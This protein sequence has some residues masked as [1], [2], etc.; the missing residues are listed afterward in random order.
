MEQAPLMLVALIHSAE[1]ILGHVSSALGNERASLVL[2]Q[3]SLIVKKGQH[4]LVHAL[5]F[6][7][8]VLDQESWMMV[9]KQV[10]F[11]G[12]VLGWEGMVTQV[13]SFFASFLWV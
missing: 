11:D 12:V 8:V 4:Y 13:Y 7:V 1:T 5:N 3:Y 9:L 6:A 10:C 2:T